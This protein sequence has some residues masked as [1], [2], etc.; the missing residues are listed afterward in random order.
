MRFQIINS[1]FLLL[2]LMAP[3]LP[4][5][6]QW[7]WAQLEPVA[8]GPEDDHLGRRA[9][10]VDALGGTHLVIDRWF[11]PGIHEFQYMKKSSNGAWS[12]PVPLGVQRSILASPYLSVHEP[13]GK[14]YLVFLANGALMLGV[15]EGSSWTYHALDIPGAGVLSA[16]SL[17]V[18]D[19]GYAH[20]AVIDEKDGAYKL[21][22]G[23]WNGS[24]FDFQ[25]LEASELGSYGGGAFPEV[26]ALSDG[27]AAISYRG[28]NY[29][30]YRI[31]VARN[32]GP[33]GKVWAIQSIPLPGFQGYGSAIHCT[34]AD[35]LHLAILGHQG[36]GMPSKVFYTSREAG[37]GDW[38]DV[39]LV[40][41]EYH[42]GSVKL[43][44]GRD[45]L[46]HIIFEETS[47]NYFT[48][49]ICFASN[50]SGAWKVGYL[51]QGDK[52]FPSFVMDRKGNGALVYEQY[53]VSGDRDVYYYGFAADP[54]L[55][56]DG[57]SLSAAS[58]GT[59]HFALDAGSAQAGRTYLLLGGVT[60]LKPGFALPG[61]VASLPLNR[62]AFTDLM[63]GLVNTPAF[64]SFMGALDAT[65]EGAAQLNAPPLPPSSAGLMMFYAYCLGNPYDFA[66]NAVSV[67]V[68]P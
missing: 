66:S 38:P 23:I 37:A 16:P 63:M 45:G 62:D 64:S 32:A 19:F 67:E 68:V 30:S 28:G 51:I 58:G 25:I 35:D 48:G 17:A 60:G 47:G 26:C 22:Y 12:A 61:G 40:S 46:S 33:G 20:V 39:Q 29:L 31:D 53:L 56:C 42:G 54:A 18:D 11:A 57:F 3:G 14:P 52:G 65:G 2:M 34:P 36:F 49:N 21:G 27:S 15:G 9:L 1:L 13:S 43:A 8:T 10:A 4:A 59:V 55:R 24:R 44:V 50:K 6:S 41:G 5:Q 7:T